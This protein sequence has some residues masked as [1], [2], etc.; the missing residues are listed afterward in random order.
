MESPVGLDLK[1]YYNLSI[2]EYEEVR[3]FFTQVVGIESAMATRHF[4]REIVELSA[5]FR[6]EERDATLKH[7]GRLFQVISKE[8]EAQ[9]TS[10]SEDKINEHESESWGDRLLRDLLLLQSAK[11]AIRIFPVKSASM[12]SSECFDILLSAANEHE[13][14][15]ADREYFQASFRDRVPLLV[16]SVE[17]IEQCRWFLDLLD[18]GRR[19]LSK[20]TRPVWLADIE[21]C[22]GQAEKDYA[23]ELKEKAAFIDRVR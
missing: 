18:C 12:K 10:K 23:G 2:K 8:L 14:Y 3:Y 6:Q 19:R 11:E 22:H 13:W 16:L 20:I 5:V 17:Q 9:S 1:H 21:F 4:A 15:I 7:I